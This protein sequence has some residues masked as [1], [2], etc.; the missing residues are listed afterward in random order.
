MLFYLLLLV[1]FLVTSE[2]YGIRRERT[3]ISSNCWC[4]SQV[5]WRRVQCDLPAEYSVPNA[6]EQ[7]GTGLVLG[8]TGELWESSFPSVFEGN[9]RWAG[10]GNEAVER[11]QNC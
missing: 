10:C 9:R 7:K 2:L 4:G 6:G 11:N 5:A 3:C 8:N 1:A